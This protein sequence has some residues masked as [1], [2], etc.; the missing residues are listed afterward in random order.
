MS[1]RT[2]DWI[3]RYFYIGFFWAFFAGMFQLSIDPAIGLMTWVSTLLVNFVF[4]PFS[5]LSAL[6]YFLT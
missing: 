2:K 1:E 5:M 3:F 6:Y 4:W